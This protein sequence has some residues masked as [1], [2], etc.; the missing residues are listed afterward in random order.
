MAT[1]KQNMK[2]LF[3]QMQEFQFEKMRENP[4]K[5]LDDAFRALD[6]EDIER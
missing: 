6:Q 4:D 2:R 3:E 1:R 5:P